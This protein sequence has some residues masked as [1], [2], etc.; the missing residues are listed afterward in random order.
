MLQIISWRFDPNQLS[1]NFEGPFAWCGNCKTLISLEL[2]LCTKQLPHQIP[3]WHFNQ[4][5]IPKSHLNWEFMKIYY[6][7]K[8]IWLSISQNH[9]Q[10][11]LIKVQ[12]SQGE[13][14]IRDFLLR[15]I[16]SI[17]IWHYCVHPKI[18]IKYR[19][20]WWIIYTNVSSVVA[21]QRWWVLNSKLFAQESTCSKEIL[22]S[23]SLNHLWFSVVGAIKGDYLDFPCENFEIH[24][25]LDVG[26]IACNF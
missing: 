5:L 11:F 20:H 26:I 2:F 12:W 14:Q 9:F 8:V 23:T 15:V 4:T 1:D 17:G 7:T 18:C 22:I 21:F 25:E 19:K 16:P 13:C 3:L 24:Y 10:S 6:K